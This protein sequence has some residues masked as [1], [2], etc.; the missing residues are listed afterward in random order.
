MEQSQRKDVWAAGDLY[1]PYVGRWSRRVARELLNWLAVPERKAWL[2]VGCG[3]G[4]LIQTI[5]ETENPNSII[6]IDP[7][8]GY[9]EYAKA[10][11]ASP[12]ARFEVGDAQSLPIDT[13]SLDVAVA[14]LVL[15]FVPQPSRAVAEMAR[16]V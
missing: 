9:T 15:S 14:G 1:E 16:V 12:C 2:D 4:A 6:G 5:I 8:P 7:S 11:I 10:R 13:A 3:T